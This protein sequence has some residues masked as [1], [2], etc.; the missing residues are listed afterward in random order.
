MEMQA[1]YS[2][3]NAIGEFVGIHSETAAGKCGIIYI[4]FYYR[5]LGV[6]SQ[7]QLTPP[8]RA[9]LPKR[10][11]CDRELKVMCE[12]LATNSEI[13]VKVYAGV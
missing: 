2:I 1:F 6:Y 9:Y 3:G 4:G 12:L 7:S 5:A 13:L 8:S 10:F 11:H